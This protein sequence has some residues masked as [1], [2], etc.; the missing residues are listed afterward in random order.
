MYNI[1]NYLNPA[2]GVKEYLVSERAAGRIKHLGY[3]DHGGIECFKR[4]LAAYEDVIEFCQIQL[5]WL[6]W[7][8]QEAKEKVRILNEKKIPIIVMEPLRGGTLVEPAGGA[9]ASFRFLQSIPGIVTILSGMSN[10]EQIQE[11]IRIFETDA[12]MD[13]AAKAVLF[14]KAK[15]MTEGVPCTA[16]R[17]CTTYC[18]KGIDIPYMLN[19][20]NQITFNPE[21]LAWYTSMAIGG[22]EKGKKPWDCIACGS[23]KEV[24]PQQIDIP[25]YLSKLSAKLKEA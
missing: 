18:P 5:N 2:F 25:G 14:E 17:Y 10:L 6:D 13:D 21:G 8:F 12:P 3:S 20:Y 9:E 1:E 11:N 4:F 24:C 16:C 15:K 22:V 7:D 23:C 19:Q